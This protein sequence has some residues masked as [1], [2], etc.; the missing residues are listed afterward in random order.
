MVKQVELEAIEN[1]GDL[2]NT[3]TT[4]NSPLSAVL[5][6]L[7][8]AIENLQVT[9]LSVGA[10][11]PTTLEV[12]SSNGDNVILPE[13]TCDLAGLMPASIC[14]TVEAHSAGF[15]T[16]ATFGAAL[17]AELINIQ[18]ALGI[19]SGIPHMGSYGSAIPGT[20]D[21]K[22]QT[23]LNQLFIT[24]LEAAPAG[25]TDIGVGSIT[26][27]TLDLTSNTGTG[28]TL[29]A[30]S[31]TEAGIFA[32]LDKEKLDFVTLTATLDLDALK[33][34]VDL[35]A[36]KNSY[37]DEEVDDRVATLI[38]GGANITVTYD[39]GLAT[40]TI[41]G[42]GA[43]GATDLAVASQTATELTITSS[44]GDDAVVPAATTSLSGLLVAADK[45]K[46]DLVSIVG[47]VDLNNIDAETLDGVEYSDIDARLDALELAFA[48]V[49]PPPTVPTYTV[50]TEDQCDIVI[51]AQL[52]TITFANNLA[53]V[54]DVEYG[55]WTGLGLGG[56]ANIAALKVDADDLS[57][58]GG[59]PAGSSLGEINL[60]SQAFNMAV[61]NKT[62]DGDGYSDSIGPIIMGLKGGNGGTVHNS[63]SSPN[64]SASSRVSSNSMNMWDAGR[65]ASPFVG[66]SFGNPIA[67]HGIDVIYVALDDDAIFRHKQQGPAKGKVF[68]PSQPTESQSIAVSTKLFNIKLRP[69]LDGKIDYYSMVGHMSGDFIMEGC[70]YMPMDTSLD[71]QSYQTTA[72]GGATMGFD[73][74]SGVRLNHNIL[75]NTIY[76]HNGTSGRFVSD[77]QESEAPGLAGTHMAFSEHNFYSKGG[78]D[79]WVVNNGQTRG[80]EVWPTLSLL[81]VQTN[82]TFTQCRPDQI[83]DPETIGR[84]GNVVYRDNILFQHGVNLI[85]SLGGHIDDGGNVLTVWQNINGRTWF[86]DN[87]ILE[88]Y[89]G[90]IA[91]IDQE[92]VKNLLNSDGY[93]IDTVYVQGNT[94]TNSAH[95]SAVGR[96]LAIFS[97]IQYL[98]LLGGNSFFT[99]ILGKKGLTLDDSGTW[100]QPGIAKRMQA[101]YGYA[102]FD[103]ATDVNSTRSYDGAAY[104]NVDPNDPVL[105]VPEWLDV[106]EALFTPSDRLKLDGIEDLADVTATALG[107][108][109]TVA[110]AGGD[111]VVVRDVSDSGHLKVVT[112]QSIGDLGGGGGGGG[113]TSVNGDAGPA[114]VLDTD[115]IAEGTNKFATSAELAEIAV[116][117]AHAAS[118]H[119]TSGA[120]ANAAQVSTPEINAGSETSPRAWSPEDVKDAV[121]AHETGGGGPTVAN[122]SNVVTA[123]SID[124]NIDTGTD[125]NLVSA[126]SGVAGLLT[127]AN[128]DA[129]VAIQLKQNF[130]TLTQA[131]DLDAFEIAVGLNDLKVSYPGVGS[132]DHDS[133]LNF[134]PDEH[135]D[136]TGT[137]SDFNTTGEVRTGDVFVTGDMVIDGDVDGRDVSVDGAALDAHLALTNEHHD[138][139]AATLDFLT[140]GSLTI[141]DDGLTLATNTAGHLLIGDGTNYNPVAMSGHAAIDALGEVTVSGGAVD[142]VHFHAVVLTDSIVKGNCVYVSGANGANPQVSLADNS[143]SN[144]HKGTVLAI[145]TEDGNHGDSI[146]CQTSGLLEGI[147]MTAFT[148]GQVVYLGLAGALTPVHPSGIDAVQRVG[149]AVKVVGGS[150]GSMLIELDSLTTINDHD[151]F[152]RT[153]TVNQNAGTSAVVNHT[154]VNDAGHYFSTNMNGSNSSFGNSFASIYNSGHGDTQYVVDGNKDHSWFTDVGDGHNGS[155]SEVMR[156]T[157]AGDLEILGTVDGRDIDADGTKLDLITVTTAIDLDAI[158]AGATADQTKADIDG[159]GL[160]HTMLDNIGTNTHAQLDQHIIDSV[161]ALGILAPAVTLN[162]LKLSATEVNVLAALAT[163]DIETTGSVEAKTFGSDAEYDNGTI[164]TDT[165]IDWG[166]GNHQTLVLGGSVE[167]TFTDPPHGV[168]SLSLRIVQDGTGSRAATLPTIAWPRGVEPTLSLA[169]S[170]TD[171]IN[172]SFRAST[173]FGSIAQGYGS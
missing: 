31:D 116:N 69:G 51:D 17:N 64:S 15:G 81:P 71:G 118:S 48:D 84:D 30:A 10:I 163:A 80:P 103:L 43:G 2:P 68:T 32:S 156:L 143:S 95:P 161:A 141:P 42:A 112:A 107:A 38:V 77:A 13:G 133:L 3:I 23:A 72:S 159:L 90:G 73:A 20:W 79:L 98:H 121:L 157:A 168:A 111:L 162:T 22:V 21:D 50:P 53:H 70:E 28:V 147:N 104:F 6:E 142:S 66:E 67:H 158:E 46:L 47:A 128:F 134:V 63:T 109:D 76:N 49:T 149:H 129:L 100:A 132:V 153:Q 165:L 1:I 130:L 93:P 11:T 169:A 82:R 78:H 16:V 150:S 58:T 144:F 125:I 135:I 138:W 139:T 62:F 140:T 137:S 55:T 45:T 65:N 154:L 60:F 131:V 14:Q 37:T 122:L 113:V 152:V 24:A 97:G 5:N 18:T 123:T 101:V 110:V 27:T 26:T 4:D 89:Y 33:A 92:T 119:S 91:C 96:S 54:P 99:D 29:P 166:N 87:E 120:E 34:A 88:S 164:T 86:W 146:M 59:N 171:I 75:G 124:I 12:V 151:G 9:D 114:V 74:K 126:S 25:G 56:Y 170:S 127:G 117:T 36:A 44:T 105:A 61:N 108:V 106:I 115:D 167:L 35:N 83:T 173:Y 41:D 52:F 155:F 39:D 40:L 19:G 172:L 136:W 57:A 102:D 148:A 145:A 85:D 8:V 94:L 160:D 7:G